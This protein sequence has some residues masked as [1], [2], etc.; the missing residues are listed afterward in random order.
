MAG[1]D[2]TKSRERAREAEAWWT[3]PD[4]G[5]QRL[6]DTRGPGNV[7]GELGLMTGAPRRSTVVAITDVEAYRL[8]KAS[9]E[10]I[11]RA[12]PELAEGI[13]V[14]LEQRRSRF[15]A[16][17]QGH[18]DGSNDQRSN[19]RSDASALGKKIREFFGL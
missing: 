2:E 7:F 1:V 11:L 12:R 17:E 8:D 5:P 10:H 9:L 14:I 4:G 6:I 3:P 15:A 19:V 18:A 13:S 16:L